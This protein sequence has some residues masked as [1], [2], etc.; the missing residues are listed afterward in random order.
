MQCSNNLKQLGLALHNY[1]D[2]HKK[3]P[4]GH[5]LM[6]WR[7]GSLTTQAGGNAFNWSFSL[8]PF[9]EQ[10][11]LYNQFDP[12]Y[13]LSENTVTQNLVLAR[14]PLASFACPSDTKP[15]QAN[16][17]AITNAATSSYRGASGAY[18]GYGGNLLRHNGLFARDQRTVF[19]FKDVVDGT[20]N[21]FAFGESKYR[22]RAAGTNTGRIY[23]GLDANPGTWA[24]G[25]VN[26]S[27]FQGQFPI[28]FSTAQGN[29]D[30][31]AVRTA[32]SEHV[33]GAQF[34]FVDGSV[35]F[36]SE[37]IY[38]T[39]HVWI[40]NANAFD[41]PNQGLGYGTYQR[42]FSVNDDLVLSEAF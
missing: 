14:T 18:D 22:M 39:G 20:S 8:L 24:A 32:G 25:S 4:I 30:G 42:L 26:C 2:T 15:P 13:H 12:R 23:G 33:G 36:I 5:Q 34:V 16:H 41:R 38:H 1:A 28:N 29:V 9:I 35:H 3:F 11:N 21:S 37:N 17:G 27:L 6:G 10:G 40:D 31:T 19:T 7:D